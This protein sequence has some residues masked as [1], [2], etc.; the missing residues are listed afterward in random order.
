MQ[1]ALQHFPEDKRRAALSWLTRDGPFWDDV[2]R[3][4]A[5]DWLESRG[6]IVTESAVGEAAFRSLHGAE[7]GLISIRPSD[8]DYSPVTV[9]W[10]REDAGLE[11]RRASL[12]NWRD[13]A[14]LEDSLRAA[15]PP[16]ESWGGLRT[17]SASRYANLRFAADCFDPLSGTPFAKAAAE[18]FIALFEI[19]DQ[20]AQAFDAAGERTPE[21]QRIYQDYFTGENALFSDSSD[22]EKRLFRSELTFTHPDNP[23]ESLFC[24]WHGKV[25]HLTLRLHYSWSGRAEE[26][27]Y[28]VYAGPKI[29]KR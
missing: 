22:S 12:K 16:I 25:R 2:R 1:Q 29:T 10:R 17:S 23:Q 15:A 20:F 28:V 4:G 14:A 24:A 27:V 6:E 3:H 26:P 7:C 21:G 13:A 8:W 18:R 5:G 9:T 11:D 19:L